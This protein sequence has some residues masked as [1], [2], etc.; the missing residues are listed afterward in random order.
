MGRQLQYFAQPFW[1]G[2][3]AGS[4]YQFLCAVDAEEGARLLVAGGA[5]GAHA[6]QQWVDVEADIYGDPETLAV[7]G[8]VPTDALSIDGPAPDPWLSDVA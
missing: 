8:D 4:R 6:W 7:I 3:K 5:D 2:P 1:V